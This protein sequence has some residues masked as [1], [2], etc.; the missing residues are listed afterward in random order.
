MRVIEREVAFQAPLERVG[1]ALES[2]LTASTNWTLGGV[3]REA[4]SLTANLRAGLFPWVD[5]A[6]FELSGGASES[7]RVVIS[8]RL[9]VPWALAGPR[10]AHMDQLVDAVL[11]RLGD[12]PG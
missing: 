8:L 11:A 10:V 6:R 2:A 1:G 12:S 4:A 7:T 3:Q 5:A 9:A